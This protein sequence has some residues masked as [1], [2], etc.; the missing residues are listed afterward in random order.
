M[1]VTGPSNDRM[2]VEVCDPSAG[3]RPSS[4][5]CDSPGERDR[6]RRRGGREGIR[7]GPEA[8]Q[9]RAPAGDL[10]GVRRRLGEARRPV[11]AH[12]A[13]RPA[14]LVAVRARRVAELLRVV[15][16]PAAHL[17]CAVDA[18]AVA[19]AGGDLL[20]PGGHEVGR[21]RPAR[22]LERQLA[23]TVQPQA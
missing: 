21:A 1:S 9:R 11:A 2:G 6:L 8:E 15:R 18:A 17:A 3:S 16:A 14:G 5:L 20:P 22:R 10:I 4:P 12:L 19:G 13:A 23:E 7:R